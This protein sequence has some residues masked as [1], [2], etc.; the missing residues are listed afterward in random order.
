MVGGSDVWGF[1]ETCGDGGGVS[2]GNS[3]DTNGSLQIS[4]TIGFKS[5]WEKEDGENKA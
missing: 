1:D 4:S 2:L 5:T 3:I